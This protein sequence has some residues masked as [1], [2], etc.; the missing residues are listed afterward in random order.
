MSLDSELLD[1]MRKI[2]VCQNDIDLS[3]QT[4]NTVF[5]LFVEASQGSAGGTKGG[6]GFRRISRTFW[7]FV[8]HFYLIKTITEKIEIYN[9]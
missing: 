4:D 1:V 7:L 9:T 5:I 6:A 8:N 2:V 3:K